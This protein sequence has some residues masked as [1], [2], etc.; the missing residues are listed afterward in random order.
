MTFAD[1]PA[2][3][4]YTENDA[5]GQPSLNFSPA[6]GSFKTETLKV[7]VSLNDA[8]VSGWY[9]IGERFSAH[10]SVPPLKRV[11]SL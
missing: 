2:T 7:T 6:G 10:W 9:Q 1:E 8:A 4:F 11:P 3:E 5:V